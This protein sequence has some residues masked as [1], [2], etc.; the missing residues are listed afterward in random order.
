MENLWVTAIKTKQ[1]LPGKN[2]APG[3]PKMSECTLNFV[4]YSRLK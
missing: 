2:L 4:D 1:K 3:C